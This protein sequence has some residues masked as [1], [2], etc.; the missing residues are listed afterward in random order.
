[1]THTIVPFKDALIIHVADFDAIPPGA[2]QGVVLLLL[3]G[4]SL[5][6]FRSI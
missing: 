1:V 6:V 3:E 4:K 2:N 5:V